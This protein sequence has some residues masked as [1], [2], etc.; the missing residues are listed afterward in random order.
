MIKSQ[1]KNRSWWR[2]VGKL[3][4]LLTIKESYLL[5]KNVL[6]LW[7]HPF[8]TLRE[9]SLEKDRSQQMLLLGLPIYVLGIGLVVVWLGR[10]VLATSVEWGMAAKMT[11][12]TVAAIT[13]MVGGYLIYWWLKVWR[14]KYE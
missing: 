11:G 1:Q 10:R 13:G 12:L 2:R 14:I 4:V 6:G 9:L 8:K 7:E 3:G 5:T